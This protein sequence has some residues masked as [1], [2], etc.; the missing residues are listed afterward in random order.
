MNILL[1]L[2]AVISM[3][4][5]NTAASSAEVTIYQLN[6]KG[7][8]QKL[9]TVQL[10]DSDFGLM[11]MPKLKG[12]SSGLHG[13]HIHENNS[14]A[15]AEKDG[16]MV[17]GLAAGGHFDPGNT[18][19]HL[20]PYR[21]GHLGDLPPLYVDENG[22]AELESLAPRI[23]LK[24]VRGRSLMIHMHGDNFSDSPKKLG[25]GGPRLACGLIPTK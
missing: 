3:A 4:S 17:P 16:K 13:F 18:G 20:G 10:E 11:I 5:Q 15:P 21:D 6:E 12:L 8:G 14:C 9:G 7:N 25:G 22:K 19:K 1:P 24:K 23:K 2:V